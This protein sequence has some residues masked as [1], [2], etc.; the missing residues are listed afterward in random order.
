MRE[1]LGPI[2]GLLLWQDPEMLERVG[3][4]AIAQMCDQLSGYLHDMTPALGAHLRELVIRIEYECASTLA[5]TVAVSCTA[6]TRLNLGTSLC[7]W[8][9]MASLS[10]L[11]H[12]TCAQMDGEHIPKP[13]L[14]SVIR[15][16]TVLA[17]ISFHYPYLQLYTVMEDSDHDESMQEVRDHQQTID[18]ISTLDQGL[19]REAT[20]LII[21]SRVF[22]VLY[23]IAHSM[24]AAE[25][26]NG[27]PL[28]STMPSAI[29]GILIVSL[30][31]LVWT[32]IHLVAF[33][34]YMLVV[35]LC[36][37]SFR[38]ESVEDSG[39]QSNAEPNA[40]AV[41]GKTSENV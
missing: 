13:V 25:V 9:C 34:V 5:R 4:A 30:A 17:L 20:A 24:I 10:Q 39:L 15:S 7:D 3:P 18:N 12:L 19:V 41:H 11:A 23:V 27:G 26:T 40:E 36:C 28:S 8:D 14:S 32:A 35:R 2:T 29:T 6:I 16:S 22:N 38:A 31:I 1:K 33:Y 37:C 21:F